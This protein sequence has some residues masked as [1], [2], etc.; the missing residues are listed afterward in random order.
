M[1][2]LALGRVSPP[3]DEAQLGVAAVAAWPAR[4]WLAA[5]AAAV[6]AALVVG[7]PTGVVQTSLY[8]RMT[9]V[10]WWD[11]PVWALS[12]VLVGLIAATYVRDGRAGPPLPDRIRR[13]MG[14]TLLSA[15]AVG[16]PICNKLVVSVIG[17]SGALNYWAP[18][19]PVLGVLSLGLVL[20]GLAVRLRGAIAC[21]L[22]VAE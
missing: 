14:A 18:I 7:V 5:F 17:L 11:Y 21:P 6:V 16:C 3:W 2:P 1:R 10:R 8:H 19:Q 12:A 9:P 15:F 22:P 4:R 20:T 13:T